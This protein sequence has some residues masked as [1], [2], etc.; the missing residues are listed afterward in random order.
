M[1]LVL[2]TCGGEKVL[3]DAGQAPH[4]AERGDRQRAAD[5]HRNRG[6]LR[7]RLKRKV[8]HEIAPRIAHQRFGSGRGIDREQLGKIAISSK[9]HPIRGPDAEGAEKVAGGDETQRSGSGGIQSS[10]ANID[11]IA[12]IEVQIRGGHI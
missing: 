3:L 11:E 8:T 5:K 1:G 6:R 12:C 7:D 2:S 4:P 9:Q 10:Q